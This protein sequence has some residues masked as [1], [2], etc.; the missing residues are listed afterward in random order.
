MAKLV[1][2]IRMRQMRDKDGDTHKGIL[3]TVLTFLVKINLPFY[4]NQV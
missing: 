3:F 1:R 4:C 2:R